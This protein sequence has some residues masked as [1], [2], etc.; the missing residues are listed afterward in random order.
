MPRWPRRWRGSGFRSSPPRTRARFTCAGRRWT[1]TGRFLGVVHF[2]RLL[3]EPPATLVSAAVDNG[4]EPL[5]PEQPLNAVTSFMATYNLVAAPVVDDSGHLLG[6]IT[7]DDV[8]D[9][10]LPGNWRLRDLH[11]HDLSTG[12]HADDSGGGGHGA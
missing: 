5:R 1:P 4:I 10:V 3:R 7:V 11:A 2:Q 8:L 9:H 12:A 6:A